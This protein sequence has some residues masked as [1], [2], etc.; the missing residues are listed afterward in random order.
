VPR[1]GKRRLSQNRRR[2][3]NDC[4]VRSPE[5]P[6]WF[7]PRQGPPYFFVGDT[8]RTATGS[9]RDEVARGATPASVTHLV[10][11]RAGARQPVVQEFWSRTEAELRD[12]QR[13]RTCVEFFN[14]IP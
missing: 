1:E 2:F 8:T 11:R 13:Q 9:S 7:R 4:S 14:A 10:P 12:Q 6:T 3:C 5:H